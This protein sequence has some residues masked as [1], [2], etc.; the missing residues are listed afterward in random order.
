VN[1]WVDEG[2]FN[3]DVQSDTVTFTTTAVPE[4]GTYGLLAGFGLLALGLRHQLK[5]RKA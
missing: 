2:T 3:I 1:G 5:D 4:P